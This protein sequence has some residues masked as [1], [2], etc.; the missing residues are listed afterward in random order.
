MW[1]RAKRV[2]KAVRLD[3]GVWARK[4]GLEAESESE[5][6]EESESG[7]EMR[8]GMEEAVERGYGSDREGGRK[9]KV[10]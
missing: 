8:R 1:C 10:E 5:G 2:G 9:G 7:D 3:E 4:V 6:S